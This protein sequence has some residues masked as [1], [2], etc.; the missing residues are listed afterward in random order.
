[1][2]GKFPRRAQSAAAIACALAASFVLSI[3]CAS[4]PTSQA[5]KA[6]T[7]PKM[8]EAERIALAEAADEKD[9]QRSWCDYLEALYKR[10][11]EGA[12]SWPMR[13]DCLAARTM[14]SPEM[15]RRTATCSKAALDKFE[16]DP[17]TREYA[18]A[19]SQ[20]GS[21]ALDA[22]EAKGPDLVPFV[23]AICGRMATC[24]DV[25]YA[26]CRD[27]LTSGLGPHLERAIG[28]MNRRG[29]TA[30]EV[31]LKKIEC[32]DMGSQVVRCLEPIMDGLLWLPG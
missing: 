7:T 3:G 24:G 16:G 29:R 27:G 8:T 21:D 12:E 2:S 19:V 18:A 23:A 5:Q 4:G 14:A 26:E 31:C 32:G 9:A 25:T 1:V 13:D 11:A 17:F 6:Q 28:A 15:L 10:A 30:L 22:V 20:C